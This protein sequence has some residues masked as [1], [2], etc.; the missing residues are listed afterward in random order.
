MGIGLQQ[1]SKADQSHKIGACD[2]LESTQVPE[3]I[4]PCIG[5]GSETQEE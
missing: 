3:L 1:E 4:R 5:E 2:A